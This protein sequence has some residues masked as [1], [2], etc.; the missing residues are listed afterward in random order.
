MLDVQDIIVRYGAREV[1]RDVSFELRSGEIVALLGPNGAGK[2][3]LV[4]ALNSAVPLAGGE[5][6]LDGK[7]LHEFSRREIARR[8]AVVAQENET[9]FPVTVLDFV[10][11]GRFAHGTA[12]GWESEEDI[13]TAENALVDCD[14][15][16]FS[17]RLMNEL[18][19]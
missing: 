10:L 15:R 16:E 13:R 7:H 9:K 3:T 17:G 4:R 12:F 14:L 18:S 5:I 1:L 6:R 8:V 19:G 2:T 11:S